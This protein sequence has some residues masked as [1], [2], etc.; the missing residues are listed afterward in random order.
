MDIGA[1]HAGHG[2]ANNAD[3]KTD[4]G[5]GHAVKT[6]GNIGQGQ[7]LVLTVFQSFSNGGQ[8]TYG[9]PQAGDNTQRTDKK[10]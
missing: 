3:G 1:M 5:Q 10:V 9:N 4:V 8:A 6:T 2:N 7:D